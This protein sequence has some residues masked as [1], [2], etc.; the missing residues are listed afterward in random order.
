MV[1]VTGSSP[2]LWLLFGERMILNDVKNVLVV[3]KIEVRD[4]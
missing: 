4:F 2:K 3:S 1:V